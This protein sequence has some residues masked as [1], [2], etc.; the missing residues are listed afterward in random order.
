VRRG[1]FQRQHEAG[2]PAPGS[3]IHGIRG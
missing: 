3:Q 1:P 2:E